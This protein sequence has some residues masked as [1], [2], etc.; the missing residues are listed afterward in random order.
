MINRLDFFKG[1]GYTTSLIY[2]LLPSVDISFERVGLIVAQKGHFIDSQSI[3]YNFE[4]GIMNLKKHFK[5]FDRLQILNSFF[6]EN[7]SKLQM[8]LTVKNNKIQFINS[9]TPLWAKPILDEITQNLN[10]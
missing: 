6:D 1:K 7:P 8:L 3:S 4:H 2:M 9:N 5:R 10:N